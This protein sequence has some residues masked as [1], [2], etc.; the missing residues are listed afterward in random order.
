MLATGRKRVPV[1]APCRVD[2][3]AV[4]ALA[5]VGIAPD[6]RPACG[7]HECPTGPRPVGYAR[8]ARPACQGA[9]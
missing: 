9:A 1:A 8:Q 3:G 2:G 4:P 5:S 6:L 7:T